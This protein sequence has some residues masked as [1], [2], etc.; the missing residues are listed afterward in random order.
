MANLPHFQNSIVDMQYWKCH[1]IGPTLE[2]TISRVN[3][4]LNYEYTLWIFGSIIDLV[5]LRVL[6]VYSE[7]GWRVFLK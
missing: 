1:I 5:L 3:K 4:H 7:E 6:I 2:M